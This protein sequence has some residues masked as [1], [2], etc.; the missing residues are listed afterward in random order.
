MYTRVAVASPSKFIGHPEL[1]VT[2]SDQINHLDS[3]DW[4]FNTC[5]ENVSEMLFCVALFVKY[6]F[7]FAIILF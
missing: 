7:E 5:F 2:L 4:V 1:P 3:D 6:F